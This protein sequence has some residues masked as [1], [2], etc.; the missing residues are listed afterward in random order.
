MLQFVPAGLSLYLE[1][2]VY[3]YIYIYIQDMLCHWLNL[4]METYGYFQSLKYLN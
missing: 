4:I 2:Y 1:S 3:L